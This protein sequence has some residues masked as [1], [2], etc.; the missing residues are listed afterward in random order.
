MGNRKKLKGRKRYPKHLK[1]E[2]L[3]KMFTLYRQGFDVTVLCILFG[4][5]V[6]SF[7]SMK[8]NIFTS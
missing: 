3:I 5:D 8:K 4:I 7:Y 6:A 1:G 2:D